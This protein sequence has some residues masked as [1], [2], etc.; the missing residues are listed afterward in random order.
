MLLLM[1]TMLQ[2]TEAEA[3]SSVKFPRYT[4]QPRKC[5]AT[6][7]AADSNE[8]V[9]CA[10]RPDKYR[11]KPLPEHLEDGLPAAERTIGNGARVGIRAEQV[12]VGGQPSQRIMVGIK[13]RS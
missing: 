8:I 3:G 1:M 13:T 9:V 12:D 6:A 5:A 7:A 11:L 10:T 2:P 4:D